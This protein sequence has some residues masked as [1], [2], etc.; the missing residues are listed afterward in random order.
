[1]LEQPVKTHNL[2]AADLK[3]GNIATIRFR[4]KLH[5][6]YVF[7]QTSSSSLS[8][9]SLTEK[10]CFWVSISTNTIPVLDVLTSGAILTVK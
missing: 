9:V 1:M 4:G 5:T 6:V 8:M 3:E 7:R 2:M 10:A